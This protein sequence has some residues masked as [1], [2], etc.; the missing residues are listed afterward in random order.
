[1]NIKYII[2]AVIIVAFGIYAVSSFQSSITP[3]VS[4]EEAIEA[5]S[6]VQVK[7][8]RVDSGNFDVDENLFKFTLQDN[9][10]KK[11]DVVYDGAKPGNFDQATEIVCVGEYKEGKFHA[12]NILVKCPSKY[13][14]EGGEHPDNIPMKGDQT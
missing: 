14:E 10:G 7:G 3:Y 2:G 11:L 4:I 9:N 6:T 5:G 8:Q 1:M 13:Q 12:K